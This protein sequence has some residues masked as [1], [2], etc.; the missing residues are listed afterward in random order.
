[1]T[2][3]SLPS[4]IDMGELRKLAATAAKIQQAAGATDTNG[5]VPAISYLRVS[6]KDQATRNGLEEGLSIPAQRKAA[7]RKADQLGAVIVKEFIEPGE[8]AK[9]AQR[10]ALQDMLDYVTENPVQYCI[11]NK[12]DR[13]ARN[14]LDDAII[15]ATLRDANISLVS[16]TENIDETPSGML[17]HGILASMAEFYS[18]NL[19]QEVLKGMTQ[20]ASMGGT[21]AKAPLGYLN[22][23]TTDAK[24]HEIRDVTVDPE[25]ADLITFAFTAYAT[26]DW[27]LSS[28]AAELEA[29]GLTTRPTPSFPSK[30]V[31]TKALHK[32]LTNPYYQGSLT[33]RGVTYDGAH[34]PLVDTETWLRVQTELAAKNQ[35][36]EKPRTHDHYLKGPLYC[37]CGAKMMIECPT[38]KSG[39]TYEYFTCSGRR[40][41]NGCTRSAILT[42]RI[43]DRIDSTYGANG[44]TPDEAD[45][46]REVLG[47]VF[48][49]LEATT[50]HERALLTTQKEKLDAERLKLVQ[51]HYADAIP[52]DL[53]K[54]EQERI[55][56]TLDAIEHRLENLATSYEDAREGLD[57]LADILTDLGDV[58]TRCEPAERRI[59]NRALFDKI[60]LDDEETVRYQPDQA[61]QAALD[62]VIP[63]H[64]PIAAAEASDPED[65]SNPA[66]LSAGQG[67]K[68]SLLVDV[69]ERCGN[70][71][72]VVKRL[73]TAW[74]RSV[75]NACTPV[76]PVAYAESGVVSEPRRRSRTPLTE[77]EV[78]AM[79]T[80]RANGVSVST[81]ARQFRVHRGTVW[82]KTHY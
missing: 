10:R 46:V 43:E 13:L 38:G 7:Q 64:A 57:Q 37:S 29:R 52:L 53:L 28:L 32:I 2:L 6:T 31:T 19:A 41:K 11:I 50:D 8:S 73:N 55:R 49:Q 68:M 44:L 63:G 58:Y 42:D 61:V 23:R 75:G 36:G 35:R 33:F 25:R 21:P 40:K 24:G 9:T 3:T 72:R 18:L 82:E 81:I 1:M 78:D 51:A 14:R 70:K 71:R 16:V 69:G 77:Q 30:P 26:G 47:A 22:V 60:I 15:H 12:V 56:T 79:R 76:E 4:G 27:T 62:C 54:S 5:L 67:S 20:K 59:L 65:T 45:R 48:D 66:R 39:I 80:A 17:M 34:D 74:N